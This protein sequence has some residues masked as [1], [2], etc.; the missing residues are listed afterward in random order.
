M[1]ETP[2]LTQNSAEDDIFKQLLYKYLPY[3]PLFALLII[4]SLVAARLYTKWAIPRYEIDATILIKDEKKGLVESKMLET[5]NLFEKSKIVENELEILHSHALMKQVV[6]NLTL[7]APVFE[8]RKSRNIPAYAYSPI[9]IRLKD[10]DNLKETEKVPFVYD[11]TT[12]QVILD[13]MRVPVNQWVTSKYGEIMFNPNPRGALSSQKI[14]LYFSLIDVKKIEYYFLA[15]LK[16]TAASKMSTII[17]LQLKD[18]VPARGEDVLNELIALYTKAEVDDKNV[19]AANTLASVENR[20]RYVVGQL[21]SVENAIQQFRTTSGVIDIS[22]QGKLYLENVG[23]YDKQIEDINLKLAVLEEME[24]FIL[25][26][27]SGASIAPSTGLNDPTLSQLLD[28]LTEA[29]LQ[30]DK[31]KSTTAE[32]SP[33]L[34]SIKEQI[35][36]LKPAI[37]DNIRNQRVNLEVS[38]NNLSN[39]SGKYNSMLSTIPQKEKQLLEISRQQAIKNQ[40]YSFLLQKREEAALSYTSTAT[41]TRVIDKAES[42]VG[43]VSPNKMIIQLGGLLGGLLMG[44]AFVNLKDVMNKTILFRKEIESICNIP[45]VA[46]IGHDRSKL[47]IVIADNKKT[48]IA[49]QFRTLRNVLAFNENHPGVKKILLSSSISG[50]GKAFIASNLATSM[51]L[52]GK[53]TVL[54]DLDLERFHVTKIFGLEEKKGIV[55]YLSNKVINAGEIRYRSADNNKLY[56]IPAG[57]NSNAAAELLVGG[58]LEDL[59]K[60]LELE[61]DFIVM[62]SGPLTEDANALAVSHFSDATIF[63]IRHNVTPKNNLMMLIHEDKLSS[64][65]NPVVVF[66]DVRGRGFGILDYGYGYGYG[67]N[68]KEKRKRKVL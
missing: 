30:Y 22:Q 31:L 32:N 55:D 34:L 68:I 61:F 45:V 13:N 62:C 48:P 29:Q 25:S 43:P 49:E 4:G 3:W 65:K 15:N 26:K 53:K 39:N 67:Y 14:P 11:G 54:L 1:Q 27:N 51:A 17:N 35:N 23:Q 41:D 58:N 7:Y 12:G 18:D 38:R 8:E 46:E 63:V 16:A 20:L 52:A 19:M 5:L 47:S 66:N 21:D 33:M 9:R 40:I 56:I 2:D 10:P 50:E 24:K 60:S 6:T 57:I 36:K 64:L 42:S 59:I 44:I 37:L 28:K